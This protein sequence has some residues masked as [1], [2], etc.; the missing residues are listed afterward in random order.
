MDRCGNC[1]TRTCEKCGHAPPALMEVNE[2]VWALWRFAGNQWRI[3]GMGQPI[4]LDLGAVKVA[5]DALGIDMDRGLLAK[6]Q[7]IEFDSLKR[8]AEREGNR[9]ARTAGYCRVC[10]EA[11]RNLDC[12]ECSAEIRRVN[13]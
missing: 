11:K 1:R 13:G 3:G 9:E 4:G 5:A 6:L 2:D 12:P 10:I 8:M 7:V